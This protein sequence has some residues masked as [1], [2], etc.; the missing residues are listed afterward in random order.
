MA[1]Q[2]TADLYENKEYYAQ[3]IKGGKIRRIRLH[4]V[5]H[6]FSRPE[7]CFQV[8]KQKRFDFAGYNFY[9]LNEIGIGSTEKEAE[10]NYGKLIDAKL[11]VVYN[12]DNDIISFLKRIE[13]APKYFEYFN[14]RNV[15]E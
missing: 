14:Y 5:V 2:S 6:S 10:L 12:S 8:I 3:L 1:V 4:G 7:I 11:P 15:K 13:M 9:K